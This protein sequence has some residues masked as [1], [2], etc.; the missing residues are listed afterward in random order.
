MT[1][2]LMI[3]DDIEVL[4]INRKYFEENDC[5]VAISDKAPE[6][7]TLVKKFKPDCILLDVMMP[8]MDGLTLCREIRKVTTVPVLFLSGKGSRILFLFCPFQM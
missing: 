8:E 6:G 3:D 5:V 4:E 2:I 7:L 1:R